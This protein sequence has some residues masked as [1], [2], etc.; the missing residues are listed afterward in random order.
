MR[1]EMEDAAAKTQ[2][3][4]EGILLPH[5]FER[6]KQIQLQQQLTMG[7]EHGLV[8]PQLQ[9]D[10]GLTDDQKAK[11]KTIND[12]AMQAMRG[13]FTPGQFPSPA[14]MEKLTKA[15]EENAKKAMDVL[16]ADQKEKLETMRGPKF[17]TTTL[18][19]GMGGNR[20]GNRGGGMVTMG[21]PGGGGGIL[22]LV[23]LEPV[24][25]EIDL[26]ADQK[27]K[28]QTLAA[29]QRDAMCAE[30]PTCRI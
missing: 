4:V 19:G 16:T 8:S 17:D 6:V 26:Q 12:E 29:E 28:L 22:M 30:W 24:Q 5:Q 10:L 15:R 7:A 11:I 18:F 2:K 21:G 1:K 9:K 23:Q 3:A 20:P 27:E 25:K 13:M 14:D